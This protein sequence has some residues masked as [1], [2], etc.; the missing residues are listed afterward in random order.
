MRIGR[1][2]AGAPRPPGAAVIAQVPCT[3]VTKLPGD[4]TVEEYLGSYYVCCCPDEFE[5]P[6]E[7]TG[8]V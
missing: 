1:I 2:R 5:E 8:I 7:C 3:T 4:A 6:C